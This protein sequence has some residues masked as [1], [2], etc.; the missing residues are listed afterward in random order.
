[1][2]LLIRGGSVHDPANGFDGDVRDPTIDGTRI[3]APREATF[4]EPKYVIKGVRP[5]VEEGE[6][7]EPAGI[8]PGAAALARM[9]ALSGPDPGE[10]KR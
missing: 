10:H 3:A 9:R 2:K 6:A 8:G 4:L 7:R 1:M 5:V